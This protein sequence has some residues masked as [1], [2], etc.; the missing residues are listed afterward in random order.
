MT[1]QKASAARWYC[2]KSAFVS[3][4][5][6][7]PT[8]ETSVNTEADHFKSQSLECQPTAVVHVFCHSHVFKVPGPI[9]T[10]K[11][12]P[13]C[14]KNIVRMTFVSTAFF[15]L[16]VTTVI[17]ESLFHV[18]SLP[19]H[20]ICDVTHNRKHVTVSKSTFMHLWMQNATRLIVGRE[21]SPQ[22]YDHEKT[23]HFPVDP[24]HQ[25]WNRCPARR[26]KHRDNLDLNGNFPFGASYATM[27]IHP[28]SKWW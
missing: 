4:E 12:I 13:R 3:G 2:A 26:V 17:V 7:G 19:L 22:F 14:S 10:C 9:S 27:N 28:R 24:G 8:V 16:N 5:L 15:I 21:H 25:N 20:A 23:H 18:T 1:C 6:H 11:I